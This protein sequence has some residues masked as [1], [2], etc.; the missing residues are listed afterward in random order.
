MFK[1]KPIDCL[2]TE[3]SIKWA[4]ERLA[5]ELRKRSLRYK[6][7]QLWEWIKSLFHKKRR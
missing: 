4:E 1:E 6:L 2:A 7:S 3:E 5:E